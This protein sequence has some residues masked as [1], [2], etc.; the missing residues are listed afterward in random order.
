MTSSIARRG[1]ALVAAALL[2]AGGAAACSDDDDGAGAGQTTEAAGDGGAAD[3]GGDEA[4]ERTAP[5]DYPEPEVFEGTVEAFY[6]V[7]DPLPPGNPGDLIRVQEL[8][9]DGD[10]P[11][12]RIMY[13]STD[14]R[15][16]ESARTIPGMNARIVNAVASVASFS[17]RL[18]A[19]S[20]GVA[21]KR[22]P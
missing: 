20:S 17:N 22:A 12:L 9:P 14:A 2:L 5:E 7:P 18:D 21:R 11:G 3:G 16:C 15:G 4:P 19:I 8:A 10:D 1:A 6:E 13:H